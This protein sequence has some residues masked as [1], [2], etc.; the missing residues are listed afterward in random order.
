[1][2]VAD[3]N[4]DP[5]LNTSIGGINIAEN[6][7]AGNVNNA[8]RELMAEFAAWLDGGSG[9]QPSDATLS[10]LAAV[11]TATN[12]LIYAASADVFE[13]ADLTA[14]ARSILA[15]TSGFQIAQAIGAVSVNSAN[16]A[17]PGHLR[18]VIGDKH[19]Q[20]GWGTF[21]ASANGYTSIAYSAPFPT[22]SFPVMS[23]V[24]EFSST[25]QDNNPGLSSASTTG[26]QVF[27]ASNA[28]ACWYIAVGY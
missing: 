6:C 17:N 12:K 14:F 24:G 22:A 10:A 8:I 1:M 16:L 28:A 3:W 9:F 26:F 2:A 5:S 18:F 19:F 27:N 20:V 7:P 15:M 23:G 13:T 11:T 21:T 25:A 4:T